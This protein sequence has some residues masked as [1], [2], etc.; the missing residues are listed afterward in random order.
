MV[1]KWPLK[2]TMGEHGSWVDRGQAWS[3]SGLAYRWNFTDNR[4]ADIDLSLPIY[5]PI[6]SADT[7]VFIHRYVTDYR[8]CI[9]AD[10]NRQK[11]L[12]IPIYRFCRYRLYRPIPIC[13]PWSWCITPLF[14]CVCVCPFVLCRL[15]P[16]TYISQCSYAWTIW[17]L[18]HNLIIICK[19]EMVLNSG[20][21]GFTGI[22]FHP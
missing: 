19:K 6:V 10:M 14:V 12:P 20:H 9:S 8:Y 22:Y 11:W 17:H 16:W 7:I 1:H 13:Q 15:N 21:G 18:C 3:W 5:Q 2:V 4:Y